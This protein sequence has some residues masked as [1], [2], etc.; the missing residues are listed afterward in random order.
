MLAGGTGDPGG[1]RDPDYRVALASRAA[2]LQ[3]LDA[4]YA[5]ML[6][7]ARREVLVAR[8]EPGTDPAA[9]DEVLHRLD[10]RSA[11]LI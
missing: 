7:A 10:L 2:Q 6:T 8:T 1:T 5:E 11:H 3:Q 4:V 9:A